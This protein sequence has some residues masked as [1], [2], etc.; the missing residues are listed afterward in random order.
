MQHDQPRVLQDYVQLLRFVRQDDVDEPVMPGDEAA[1]AAVAQTM[2]AATATSA[3]LHPSPLRPLLQQ[4][5]RARRARVE[6][7]AEAV[8]AP[9]DEALDRTLG[10][11]DVASDRDT[12]REK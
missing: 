4:K 6:K 3:D 1:A 9:G 8:V 12:Q 5:K 7:S 2:T 10:K 11:S